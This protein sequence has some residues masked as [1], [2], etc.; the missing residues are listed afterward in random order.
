M[1][2][3]VEFVRQVVFQEETSLSL[4]AP[5]TAYLGVLKSNVIMNK[6]IVTPSNPP[7]PSY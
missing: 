5:T 4:Y 6:A 7:Y 1:T 2:G 3:W